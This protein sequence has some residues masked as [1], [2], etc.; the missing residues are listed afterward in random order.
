MSVS[1]KIKKYL[2]SY[3]G[4]DRFSL[5]DENQMKTKNLKV[6]D[7]THKDVKRHCQSTNQKIQG[8]TEKAL[9]RL[10]IQEKSEAKA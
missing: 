2:A 3:R 10:V 7:K 1:E 5:S 4:S 8:F 6:S 9:L